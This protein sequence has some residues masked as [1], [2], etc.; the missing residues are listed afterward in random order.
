M[1][2]DT[3]KDENAIWPMPAFRFRVTWGKAKMEFSEVSGLNNEEQDIE[4]R[5]GNSKVFYPI[6]MPRIGKV[7]NVSMKRGVFIGPQN[8]WDW[9][10]QIKLNSINKGRETVV[11]HLV[12]ENGKSS[13]TWMLNNAYPTKITSADLKSDGNEAQIDTIEIAYETLVIKNANNA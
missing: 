8:Y 3:G 2:D 11:I 6:K 5:H 7:D 4:Y 13:M 9:Y 10:S 12:D 1:A